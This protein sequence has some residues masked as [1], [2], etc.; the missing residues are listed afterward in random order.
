MEAVAHNPSFAHK[1][2]VPKHVGKHFIDMDKRVHYGSG[3]MTDFHSSIKDARKRL[4]NPHVQHAHK[5]NGAGV[6]MN[7]TRVF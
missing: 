4:T 2:G 6:E 5:I 3:F 7:A 1:V